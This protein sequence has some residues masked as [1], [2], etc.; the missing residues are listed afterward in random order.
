MLTIAQIKENPQYIIERLGVKG[1][2]GN[3]AIAKVLELSKVLQA[4]SNAKE[5]RDEAVRHIEFV[6]K[7]REKFENTSD[8]EK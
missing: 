5:M 1:F 8:T 6:E 3:E 4:I 7:T 2:D